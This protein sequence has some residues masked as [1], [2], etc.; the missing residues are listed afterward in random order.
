MKFI[1]ELLQLLLM[2]SVC[3][4]TTKSTIGHRKNNSIY[5]LG[6][7]SSMS[8]NSVSSTGRASLGFMRS[9]FVLKKEIETQGYNHP[10]NVVMPG[11]MS[12][13]VS[14]SLNRN[15]LMTH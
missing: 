3:N 11:L 2:I 14:P 10:E 5:S 12:V 6:A 7:K 1:Q 8:M 9:S 13:P 15:H 4:A